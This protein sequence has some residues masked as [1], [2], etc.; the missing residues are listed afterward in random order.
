MFFYWA[1]AI[2]G[3]VTLAACALW[4]DIGLAG[5]LIFFI[6]LAMVFKPVLDE[7]EMQLTHKVQSFEAI[8]VSMVL[9]LIYVV[10]PEVNWF[11]TY[12]GVGLFARGALGLVIFSRQ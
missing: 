11:H 3:I 10:F 5:M 1:A 6:G 4:G 8:P 9:G 2:S 12:V 7:R